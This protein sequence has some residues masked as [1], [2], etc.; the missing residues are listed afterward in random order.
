MKIYGVLSSAYAVKFTSFCLK[1]MCTAFTL[2]SKGPSMNPR[3]TPYSIFD[4]VLKDNFNLVLCL[5]PN[6]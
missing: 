2:K 3:S 4:H 6:K 5:Q 1:N